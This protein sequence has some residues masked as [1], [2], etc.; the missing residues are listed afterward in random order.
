MIQKLIN[1]TIAAKRSIERISSGKFSVSDAGRC[2]LMRFW[3]RKGKQGGVE[4]TERVFRI[5]EVGHIFEKWVLDLMADK[6]ILR[7]HL[8]EDE[9]RKGYLDAMIVDEQNKKILLDCKTVH[10]RKFWRNEKEGWDKD[11]HYRY[12]LLTYAMMLP[13][14]LRPDECRLVYISKDDLCIAEIGVPNNP[15]AFLPVENDWHEIITAWREDR[16]PEPNP[17]SWECEY[18]SY[19]DTCEFKLVKAKTFKEMM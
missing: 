3:K 19:Q 18:C 7:Q 16:E 2:R 1:D 8:V 12:Q 11:V 14:A 13:A 9:H 5:F 10:S 15:D 17:M 4:I 6:I